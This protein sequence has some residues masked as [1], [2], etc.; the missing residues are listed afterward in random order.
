MHICNLE[1]YIDFFVEHKISHLDTVFEME[2]DEVYKLLKK[3]TMK[4]V[5]VSHFML[6]HT[7]IFYKLSNNDDENKVV[8]KQPTWLTDVHAAAFNIRIKREFSDS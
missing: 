1:D 6:N 4:P 5:E 3:S 7:I 2:S 8:C